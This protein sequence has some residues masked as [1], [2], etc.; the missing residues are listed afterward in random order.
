MKLILALLVFVPIAQVL[1][2]ARIGPA[3]AGREQ[4]VLDRTTE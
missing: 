2:F 1:E 3:T 4:R